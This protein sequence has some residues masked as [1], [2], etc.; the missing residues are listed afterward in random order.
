VYARLDRL[1]EDQRAATTSRSKAS[2]HPKTHVP[3]RK[4]GRPRK[5]SSEDIV[6][7][8]E[9][10]DTP[11]DGAN[12]AASVTGNHTPTHKHSRFIFFSPCYPACWVC[13]LP[14]RTEQ[15]AKM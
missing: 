7:T 14:F 12:T 9:V 6:S 1:F 13:Q 15:R 5:A 11:S 10:D 4:R 8:K 2:A 3:G